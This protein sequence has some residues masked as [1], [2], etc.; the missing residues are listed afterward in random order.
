MKKQNHLPRFGVGPLFSIT[1]TAITVFSVILSVNNV[2]H[3]G[4]F[5]FLTVPFLILGIILILLGIVFWVMAL[6][7]SK[8]GRHIKNNRLVTDGVYSCVR[9]PIYSAILMWCTGSL[10]LAN[11]LWLCILP[12]VY[13]AFLTVLMKNTEEKWLS[14]LYGEEYAEYC[15]NVNRCIP[16]IK[17]SN[18]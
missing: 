7:H 11:D 13:W 16:W 15:K 9:N 17:R 10:L 2:I 12:F 6:F 3:T 18:Q 4:N 5:P 1:V 8:I 14:A